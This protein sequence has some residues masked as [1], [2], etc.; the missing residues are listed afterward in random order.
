MTNQTW[1]KT[2]NENYDD[3]IWRIV[4]LPCWACINIAGAGNKTVWIRLLH[5]RT[6]HLKDQGAWQ[7]NP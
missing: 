4:I 7:G 3:W 6:A 1:L 2:T 5:T